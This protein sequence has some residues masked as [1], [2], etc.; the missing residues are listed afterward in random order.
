ME[1]VPAMLLTGVV[2]IIG[3]QMEWMRLS[4]R[5]R[6]EAEALRGIAFAHVWESWERTG[7]MAAVAQPEKSGDWNILDFPDPS[8]LPVVGPESIRSS[9]WRRSLRGQSGRFPHWEVEVFQPLIGQWIW[10]GIYYIEEEDG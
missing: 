4:L 3:M 5:A 7:G 8:W 2:L 10:W 1:A 6:E 9:M